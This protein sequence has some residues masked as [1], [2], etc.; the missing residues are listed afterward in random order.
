MTELNTH[1]KIVIANV[2]RRGLLK[3]VAATGG[4]V[5]AAQVPGVKG[6]FAAYPTGA[7][8][9][10]N[11]VVTNPKVFVSIGNDGIVSI[12]AAR[13]EMGNGAARTAL[14]MIGADELD[15]DWA[16]VRVVQSPGDERTYGNQDT[17]GSR[18]ARHFIQP[19]RLCGATSRLMLEMP[20]ANLWKVP[21]TGVRAQLHEVVHQPSGRKATYG[22]LAADA[23]ALPVPEAGK[24]KL[25]EPS[26]F[27]YIGKGAVRI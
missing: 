1:R 4:L 19:M 13:A 25:K 21:V 11:G 10:P 22:Q 20:A 14:P 27:R 6:A 23:A 5:L 24:V 2:S 9:M 8:S 7:Q 26:A 12:V 18:S 3:G 17:D 16:R 15:A